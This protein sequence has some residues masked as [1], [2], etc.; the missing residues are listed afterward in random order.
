MLRVQAALVLTAQSVC[1]WQAP[2]GCF[3]LVSA[4]AL[5][6][7]GEPVYGMCWL[8]LVL[9]RQ[10]GS[11]HLMGAGGN[12]EL[13]ATPLQGQGNP[14]Q[15]P[16]VSFLSSLLSLPYTSKAIPCSRSKR[17]AGTSSSR[18]QGS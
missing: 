13:P 15:K 9:L 5:T 11:L 3:S 14:A 16:P 10:G 7:Q 6:P 4:E 17:R 12:R 18:L 1:C 8:C 2:R